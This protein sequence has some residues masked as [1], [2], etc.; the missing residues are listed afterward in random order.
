M[1]R[2]IIPGD[3]LTTTKVKITYVDTK[4]DSRERIEQHF[5]AL[6]YLLGRQPEDCRNFD[7]DIEIFQI[8]SH[9]TGDCFVVTFTNMRVLFQFAIINKLYGSR[10][11]HNIAELEFWVKDSQKNMYV[12]QKIADEPGPVKHFKCKQD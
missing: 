1:E 10:S 11:E 2:A 8:P 4:P 12:W 9:D 6:Y 5:K 7:G 3:A